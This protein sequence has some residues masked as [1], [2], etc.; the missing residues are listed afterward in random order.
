M[1]TQFMPCWF[2]TDK[3]L[4]PARVFGG[5]AYLLTGVLVMVGAMVDWYCS[6]LRTTP[7]WLF[8]LFTVGPLIVLAVSLHAYAELA[9]FNGHTPTE[10]VLI[11]ASVLFGMSVLLGALATWVEV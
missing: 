2:N 10:G 4:G 11:G 6:D 9:K 1:I 3:D 8:L 7:R 5:Q